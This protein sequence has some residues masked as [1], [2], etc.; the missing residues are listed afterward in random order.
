ML[1]M[2]GRDVC[3]EKH[4]GGKVKDTMYEKK[5]HYICKYKDIH[6]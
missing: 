1:V 3:Q 6:L 4:W 2:L 5:I